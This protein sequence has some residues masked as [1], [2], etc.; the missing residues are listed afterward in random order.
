MTGP[1]RK[2]Q[3]APQLVPM[4]AENAA[5]LQHRRV[6]ARVVHCAVMPRIDMATEQHESVFLGAGDLGGERRDRPPRGLDLGL[7][8]HRHR[9]AP[10]A[11][12]S[13]SRHPL[14]RPRRRR[15]CG[16][17]GA[18]SGV[19]VPQTGEI[20]ISCSPSGLT[21]IIPAAPA[22][23]PRAR[24]RAS[25]AHPPARSHRAHP[26]PHNRPRSSLCRPRRPMRSIRSARSPAKTSG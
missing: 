11:S 8:P 6:R 21:Q 22:C 2:A 7:E 12:P 1:E 18:V 16:K 3:P 24:R 26:C 5:D 19:G 13:A 20:I 10:R 17:Y 4:R 14:C 25:R 23:R 9:A 15:I